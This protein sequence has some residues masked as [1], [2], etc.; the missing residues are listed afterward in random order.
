MLSRAVVHAATL[1]RRVLRCPDAASGCNGGGDG[2]RAVI[3]DRSHLIAATRFESSDS[4]LLQHLSF[5]RTLCTCALYV[6]TTRGVHV[7]AGAGESTPLKPALGLR[8]MSV[9]AASLY[10]LPVRP[11]L[12]DHDTQRDTCQVSG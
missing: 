6:A 9:A 2:R 12:L 11:L 3:P 4:E 10:L 5:F 1:A 8:W 7:Q